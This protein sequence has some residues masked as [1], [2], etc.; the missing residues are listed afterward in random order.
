[1]NMLTIDN[2][3]SI[4]RKTFNDS[5]KQMYIGEVFLVNRLRRVRIQ[6]HLN[7][8]KTVLFILLSTGKKYTRH[9]SR[10]GLRL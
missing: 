5:Y 7:N 1:M 4:R 9:L 8:A 2:F 10:A 3:R 6:M